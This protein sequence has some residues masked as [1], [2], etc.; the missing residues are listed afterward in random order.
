[1]YRLSILRKAFQPVTVGRL[2]GSFLSVQIRTDFL[3]APRCLIY[4]TGNYRLKDMVPY[5][6]SCGLIGLWKGYSSRCMFIFLF[7]R[8]A[9]LFSVCYTIS[10][11]G[12]R[13]LLKFTSPLS[14]L[15][16][17]QAFHLDNSHT[18]AACHWFLA[19]SRT[20]S[21]LNRL[22]HLLSKEFWKYIFS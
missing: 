4:G 13:L 18:L 5:S 7:V 14:F 10:F 22:F 8:I 15:P 3:K 16:S 11:F 19:D 1:M 12:P 20:A 9:A 21:H 17:G 2:F 6:W